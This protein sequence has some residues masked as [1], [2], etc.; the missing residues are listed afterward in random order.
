M[1]KTQGVLDS[2]WLRRGHWREGDQ[3]SLSLGRRDIYVETQRRRQSQPWRVMKYILEGMANE[4]P[5]GQK[6]SGMPEEVN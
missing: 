3:G 2:I 1:K 6:E 4:R 5:L